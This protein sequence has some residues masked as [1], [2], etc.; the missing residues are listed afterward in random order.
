M[1]LGVICGLAAC[2]PAS[3][4]GAKAPAA[5]PPVVHAFTQFS[6]GDTL[7]L[8]QIQLG[9]DDCE[10]RYRSSMPDGQ[11]S[12]VYFLEQG[13]L[14]IDAKKIGDTW[15]IISAPMLDPSTIP[16][17]DRLAEWDRAADAQNR[18]SASQR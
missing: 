5:T 18:R 11:M 1:V 15:V 10:V 6:P 14:H 4:G 2:R 8:V 16:A 12:M 7:E 9:L 17:A 3:P 13:N